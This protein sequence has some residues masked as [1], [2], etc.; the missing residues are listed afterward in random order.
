V[1]RGLL[2]ARALGLLSCGGGE[3]CQRGGLS[4]DG[5]FRVGKC[6]PQTQLWPS[7]LQ[8]VEGL[9]GMIVDV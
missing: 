2:A 7:F 6:I 3:G 9:S 8:Q 1:E 4:F 5:S